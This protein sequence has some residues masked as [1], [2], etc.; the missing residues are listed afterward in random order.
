MKSVLL[1]ANDDAGLDARLQAALDAVRLFDGHLTCLQVTPF[2]AFIMGDPFGG[3]YALPTV[4]NEIRE[5]E[6]EHRA[7]LEERLTREGIAWDWLRYDGSPAQYI[8]ERSRLSDLIVLT[9]P[10]RAGQV[11]EVPSGV[12][13]DVAIHAR[14]PLLAVPQDSRG[15]DLS[16]SAFLAWNG[17]LEASHALRLALPILRRASAI[18]IVTVS[19]DDVDF[20]A[21]D[22]CEYLARHGLRTELH[23]WKREGRSTADTLLD[24][25]ALLKANYILMGAYGHSRIREAVLGGVTRAMLRR[26][27]VP[28]LLGH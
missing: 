8:V 14:A 18:H 3:V 1:Y 9:L 6:D 11:D 22:A 4:L 17:S 21:T 25:A 26:S 23:D 20:P 27:P 13:G 2:D 10:A 5:A 16:G 24:A 12:L 19:D 15:C 7:K 28:L